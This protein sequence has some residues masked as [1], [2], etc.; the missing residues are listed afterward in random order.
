MLHYLIVLFFGRIVQTGMM[1]TL[2]PLNK[3]PTMRLLITLLAVLFLTDT[4]GQVTTRFPV[5][6]FNTYDT[7]IFGLSVG[8]TTSEEIEN[9]TS[10]GLRFELIGNGLLFAFI[11]ESPVSNS[12]SFHNQVM[13]HPYSEEI[14]GINLSPFGGWCDCN[15]NGLNLNGVGSVTRGVNGVSVSVFMNFA[16]RHNGIQGCFLMNETFHMNGVQLAV[17]SNAS[18][19]MVNGIQ[20][21]AF[22][23]TRDLRGVQIGLV[24]KST[25]VKG[26]QIGIWNVN[27]KR[28]LPFINF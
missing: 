3:S 18:N 28:K 6:R 2:L 15:V 9:V 19:G 8:L 23:S 12:D 5:C 21:S 20:I 24:N 1:P 11:P 7:K 26:L 16:E 27:E 25:T 4:I 22:N 10:N 14:N 13:N 17:G